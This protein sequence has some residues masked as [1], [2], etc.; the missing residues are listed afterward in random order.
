M[1]IANDPLAELEALRI[2]IQQL[3]DA[4]TSVTLRCT[5]STGG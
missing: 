2:G 4:Y 5:N 1:Q 3:V